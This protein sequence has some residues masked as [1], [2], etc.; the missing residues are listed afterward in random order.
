M[1]FYPSHFFIVRKRRTENDNTK[2]G[3]IKK[4]TA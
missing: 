1:N 4:K 3:K 2:N